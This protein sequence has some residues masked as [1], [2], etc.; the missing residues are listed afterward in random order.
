MNLVVRVIE[1]VNYAEYIEA[2]A[3]LRISVFKE[4]PY[5]YEGDM[6]YERHYLSQLMTAE[7]P[8]LAII[9]DKDRIVGAT[10]AMALK[11]AA[12]DFQQPFIDHGD[13]IE[14][15]Y[16]CAESVL[17]PEYRGQ[18]L[19]R[20]LFNVR[21]HQARQVGARYCVFCSVERSSDDPRR[22]KDYVP[23]NA[24]WQ[25]FGYELLKDYRAKLEWREI[26]DNAQSNHDLLYWR[27][28]IG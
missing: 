3:Q 27:K 15:Y 13:N 28:A 12:P 20:E 17:L 10:T 19:Y 7:S 6:E 5:C 16:Y 26:G 24:I 18:G 14:D 8:L 1:Q 9:E 2:L 22:P 25:H 21:E 4:Y 23:L 11:E